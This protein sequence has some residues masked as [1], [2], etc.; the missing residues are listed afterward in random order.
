[1]IVVNPGETLVLLFELLRQNPAVCLI[2]FLRT[3]ITLIFLFFFYLKAK[4]TLKML[5]IYH[6]GDLER[7]MILV[8]SVGD[9]ISL[10][11]LSN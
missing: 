5:T 6:P 3:E 8:G 4:M 11:D 10:A 2:L 9:L 7:Q 1:M